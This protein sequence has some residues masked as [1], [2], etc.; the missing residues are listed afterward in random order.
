MNN[1]KKQLILGCAAIS[2][3][4]LAMLANA[5][6]QQ[7][8]KC[9][10]QANPQECR[11]VQM[12]KFRTMR[13]TKWHDELKITPEQEPAWKAFVQSLPQPRAMKKDKS[14]DT[15]KMSA[16]ERVERHLAMMEKRH[17]L[18]QAHLV[19]LKALYAKLTPE[20]QTLLNTRFAQF[21]KH[22]HQ[23][24]HGDRK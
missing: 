6:E 13:A 14:A 18:M 8:A 11:Q 23:R 21:E 24:H 15:E 3:T 5:Q 9:K 16:P 12:E 2:F 10:D 17:A 19:A 22:R 20:Q 7:W 1:L 4:S